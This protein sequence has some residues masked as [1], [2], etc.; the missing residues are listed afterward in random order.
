MRISSP[1]SRSD[2]YFPGRDHGF[3]D[4]NASSSRRWNYPGTAPRITPR[5]T[6]VDTD[7]EFFSYRDAADRLKIT[8]DSVRRTAR[9]KGWPRKTGNDGLGRV[10]I[11]V[12][13]LPK[14][15]A[16]GIPRDN[17][18]DSPP[19]NPPGIFA[20]LG[21][22][23]E[24]HAEL[25]ASQGREIELQR[26]LGAVQSDLASSV[27]REAGQERLITSLQEDRDAWRTQARRPFWRR[28]SA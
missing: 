19:D 28:L 20:L 1:S 6:P 12:D 26:Q 5:I 7:F 2:R 10:G 22:I 24:L 13:R 8:V 4:L 16:G 25:S 3:L 27:A 9:R 23:E 18:T 21:K 11:P 14:D 15:T 17:P